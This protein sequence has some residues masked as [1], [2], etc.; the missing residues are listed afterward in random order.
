[1]NSTEVQASNNTSQNA[2]DVMNDTSNEMLDHVDLSSHDPVWM[3]LMFKK[4]IEAMEKTQMKTMYI[5][6]IV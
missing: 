3:K 6:I 2:N 1:M 4:T 5:A